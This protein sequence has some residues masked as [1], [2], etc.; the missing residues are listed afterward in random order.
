MIRLSVVRAQMN[1][2]TFIYPVPHMY[3]K[4]GK[5]KPGI[6]TY[7]VGTLYFVEQ[8]EQYMDMDEKTNTKKFNRA[9]YKED[10]ER[11]LL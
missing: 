7:S 5:V 1:N 10:E 8:G 11:L 3:T 4:W 6:Y 9:R 2:F